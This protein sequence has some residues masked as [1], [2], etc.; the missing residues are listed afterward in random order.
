M[1][2][3]DFLPGLRHHRE[4]DEEV[5][6]HFKMAIRDG[7]ASGLS[8]KDA[9]ASA[10]REFGNADLFRS[11]TREVWGWT[12]LERL[13]QDIGF[14]VRILRKSPSFTLVAV[15]TLALGIGANTAIFSVINGLLIRSLPFADAKQ[16][17]WF[18]RADTTGGPSAVTNTS[19]VY[20]DLRERNRSLS[21]MAG[22]NA[23]FPYVSY[24]VTGRGDPE[25]PI[26]V[27]ITGNFLSMLGVR[28]VLGRGFLPEECVRHGRGA[29]IL[30][31]AYWKHR[32]AADPTIVGQSLTINGESMAVVGVLPPSF[33]FSSVFTPGTKVDL[34]VPRY[35]DKD[36]DNHG[37]ELSIVGRLKPGTTIGTAQ[38]EL[39]GLVKVLEHERGWPVGVI[40]DRL[41][42]LEDYVT[43]DLRR[44]LLVLVAA[45]GFV[46]LIACVNLSNLLLARAAARKREMAFRMAIGASRFRLI[47][48]LLTESV[49]LS[50][51]GCLLALPLAFLGTRILA[52]LQHTSIPLL[53][54][55]GIDLRAFLFALGISVLTG[56]LFGL[57]PAMHA[58]RG[59]INDAL[60]EGTAGAGGGIHRSWTRSALV[61]SEVA[62]SCVLL[63]GAGLMMKSFLK[64][65]DTDPGF[66]PDHVAVV[67]IDPGPQLWDHKTL[68]PYLDQIV[69]AVRRVPGI[70]AASVSDAL[71]FDRDRSWGFGVPGIDFHGHDP[72]AFIRTVGPGYFSVMRV[73]LLQGR[74]FNEHDTLA[75]G[76]VVIINQTLARRI[77]P[78]QSPLDRQLYING[79]SRI[80]GV[81]ADVKH[82]AMDQP[83]GME[84]YFP[85]SQGDTESPDLVVRTTLPPD[86][87]AT[88]IRRAIWSFA[89][90]QPL[91]EFRTMDQMVDIATS[92]RR[93]TTLLLGIFAVLAL[94]LASVGIYGVIAYSVAQRTRELGIRMAL[95]AKGKQ[96]EWSV[97]KDVLVLSLTG[98][99]LGT[100]GLAALSGYL[101][102]L[103][104]G[105]TSTDPVV[106]S[107]ALL[108]LIGV[109][110]AA[111]Y[112]PARQASRINPMSALRLE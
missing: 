107:A 61:V 93:F 60:K 67:R 8:E 75:S 105:V 30:G 83:S 110:T 32:F 81:V 70:E 9:T 29:V 37:N 22:Y 39:T 90:A 25:R 63:G 102:S 78:G 14:G 36:S 56:L 57:V 51:L 112:V 21:D 111:G 47:R 65:L 88:S 95:G 1:S 28:P 3:W 31:N 99:V 79:T 4:V 13:W 59:D 16:L 100:A 82:S 73:P 80:I 38:A 46:L 77:F 98:A 26:G 49:M 23:F 43:G 69:A 52:G 54:Q 103:L 101:S 53:G 20:R 10:R 71:P 104:F 44:P 15:V 18:T 62:L 76:H 86:E 87:M 12:W 55:V 24:N 50:L 41:Q 17:V 92:S 5:E 109:A 27:E 72:D 34:F 96:I 89:P 74:D 106:F 40:A 45:V 58:A 48:Q 97:V 84:T 108:L 85:Y 11:K 2:V 94:V 91:N 64:L 6:A 19:F 42:S 33:D 7:I 66:R 68:N 35:I